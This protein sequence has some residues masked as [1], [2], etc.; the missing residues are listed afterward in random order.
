MQ[1]VIM[2][3]GPEVVHGLTAGS[4]QCEVLSDRSTAAMVN[5]SAVATAIE[6]LQ[7]VQQAA[8][9]SLRSSSSYGC[10]MD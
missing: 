8:A 5:S 9:S 10:P 7:Q 4:H 1:T 3:A 2:C 6:S